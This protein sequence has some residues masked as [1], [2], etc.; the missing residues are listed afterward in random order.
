MAN[1]TFPKGVE[2][3]FPE[4]LVKALKRR[5]ETATGLEFSWPEMR[6]MIIQ[7]QKERALAIIRAGFPNARLG[8]AEIFQKMLAGLD[9]VERG[10]D[11][12]MGMEKLTARTDI[13]KLFE[14]AKKVPFS[15]QETLNFI[16]MFQDIRNKNGDIDLNKL[17][18]VKVSEIRDEMNSLARRNRVLPNKLTGSKPVLEEAQ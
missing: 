18:A 3:A 16:C 8:Q 12:D 15:Y 10:V 6:E 5:A 14:N 1:K 4:E 7:V 11:M 9:R 2:F 13:H 17:T